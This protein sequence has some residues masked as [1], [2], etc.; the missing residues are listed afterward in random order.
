MNK[1]FTYTIYLAFCSAL[2][3]SCAQDIELDPNANTAENEIVFQTAD[4]T[5]RGLINNLGTLG[6]KIT[7][8]GYHDGTVLASTKKPLNGKSL[9]YMN[10]RWAVVDDTDTQN[11]YKPITYFWEGDG[12]YKF[13]GW[14]TKDGTGTGLQAPT[15]FTTKYTNTKDEPY[16]LEVAGT[17]DKDYNQFDFLYSNVV[18]RVVSGNQGKEAVPLKMNHLFAAFSIGISNT[19]KD[20][21]KVKRIILQRLHTTGSATIDFSGDNTAVTYTN[22]PTASAYSTEVLA[23]Y[24][25]EY[26]LA[27]GGSSQKDIFNPS[28]TEEANV[29]KY[30]MVWP[31]AESV[32]FDANLEGKTPE[33]EAQLGAEYDKYYPLIMEYSIGNESTIRKKRMKFPKMAWQPG[34]KYSFNVKF[35]DKEISLD[36]QV[37]P[38]TYS[39]SAVD[40][41]DGTIEVNGNNS[42]TWDK[43]KGVVDDTEAT[44][45][46][47]GGQPVEATFALSAPVGGKWLVSFKDGD[48]TS[49]KIEDDAE[50]ANDGIGPIDG[51]IHRIKVTPLVKNPTRDYQVRLK[52]SVQTADGKIIPIDDIIQVEKN[53]NG[54]IVYENGKPKQ[55]IYTIVLKN[56]N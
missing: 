30:Y 45:T 14:L 29:Q 37:E 15:N 50:D 3:I 17:L 20:A 38:W 4:P 49:F 34:M 32:I 54:E 43:T 36:L 42:L 56:A 53:A 7:L 5:T 33:E 10:D 25:S 44:V 51:A 1:I 18:N 39:S 35:A 23:S 52:F 28:A 48:V 19:S 40:F 13:F 24:A 46:V 11:P 31:Q 16:T 9:T 22:Y 21:I 12:N 8:Y 26:T 55:K 27:A 2:L 6:T 47:K 41:S